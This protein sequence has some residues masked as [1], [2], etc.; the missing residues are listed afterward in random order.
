MPKNHI[1]TGGTTV[2]LESELKLKG[3]T[4]EYRG[5]LDMD[6]STAPGGHITLELR[7]TA[8]R[9][10]DPVDGDI[11]IVSSGSFKTKNTAGLY[12]GLIA[13]GTF[14][15]KINERDGQP[16]AKVT[17]TIATTS[18]APAATS[19][20][21]PP[22]AF[23]GVPGPGYPTGPLNM[24]ISGAQLTTGVVGQV[25][26]QGGQLEI[27]GR[28]YAAAGFFPVTINDVSRIANEIKVVSNLKL[29]AGSGQHQGSLDIDIAAAPGGHV[30]LEYQGTATMTGSAIMSK[31]SFKTT[32]TTGTFAGLVADGSYDMSIVE[33]ASGQGAPA[34]ITIITKSIF[35]PVAGAIAPVVA[36]SPAP[37][38]G[39]APGDPLSISMPDADL[40]I[41]NLGIVTQ[42]ADTLQIK[43]RQYQGGD[44]LPVTING[45]TFADYELQV[46]SDLKLIGGVG[47]YKGKVDIHVKGPPRG[48]LA[49]ELIGTVTMRVDGLVTKF[50]SKGT[51]TVKKARGMFAGLVGEGNYEMELNEKGS[52][53]GSKVDFGLFIGNAAAAAAL[54]SPAG[55]LT[56]EAVGGPFVGVPGPGY[57]TGPLDISLTRADLTLSQL[58]Q[59]KEQAGQMEIKNRQYQGSGAYPI[60]INGSAL[61]ASQLAMTSSLKLK[62][63]A[64]EQGGKIDIDVST[65]PGGHITLDYRGTAA[66]EVDPL[67]GD[68]TI[69]SGG[70][71]KTSKTTGLWAGL[72]A[73][74]TY[75]MKINERSAAQG[76]RVTI[77]IATTSNVPGATAVAP[78][79]ASGS[80]KGYAT[81]LLDISMP[82]TS[83][84]MTNA[85]QVKEADGQLEIKGRQYEGDEG[86]VLAT[87]NGE[88]LAQYDVKVVSDL[89]LKG[90]TGEHKGTV[91]IETADGRVA[92]EYQGTA[93]YT[94]E[95]EKSRSK[96]KSK[97]SFKTTK[98]T[99]VFNGLVAEG[100]YEMELTDKG[101]TVGSKAELTLTT[102][103]VAPAAAAPATSPAPASAPAG[104]SSATGTSTSGA[105]SGGSTSGGSTSGAASGGST[106]G[107]STS[108]A[109]SGGSTSGGSTSGSS[110]GGSTSGGSTSGS[111]SGGSTSG[112]STSGATS[113]GSSGGSTSGGSGGGGSDDKVAEPAK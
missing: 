15:E 13:S 74:G 38:S 39:F 68:I 41:T 104:G 17:I 35:P 70:S 78:A 16:G 49:L 71:F 23:V 73:D 14:A 56:P 55:A 111:S 92:L 94:V 110:S 44:G 4:G 54:P 33:L 106:S 20:A 28:Q 97:G 108:G 98:V 80:G 72:V 37:E 101:N 77:T 87:L 3:D 7:G 64:G 45:A 95:T 21:P 86:L 90:D 107:G 112:G 69:L 25:N 103:S 26:E 58:G 50:N 2:E 76:V 65:A 102:S 67:T 48:D 36:I 109:T 24:T 79:K 99:G 66:R 113:G 88:P 9:E 34:M 11:E 12:A 30:T 46:T 40:T 61:T 96:I 89:K 62:G 1:W 84:T 57:P 85:G 53:L 91:E 43:G 6:V 81:G 27:K 8:T 29:T 5:T 75:T 60:T 82:G 47:E 42:G 52:V 31:G 19:V 18:A 100:T 32:K 22:S 10:I 93:T 63:D 51:Y 83:L 105:T 59:V